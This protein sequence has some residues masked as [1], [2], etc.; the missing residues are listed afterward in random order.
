MTY[1]VSDTDHSWIKRISRL[2]V[3]QLVTSI[4]M[5]YMSV[6]EMRGMERPVFPA[7]KRVY[8]LA[9]LRRSLITNYI[10][11]NLRACTRDEDLKI[12]FEED[13]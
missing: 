2:P 3:Y 8:V 10:R 6:N 11:H 5:H 13:G 9:S 12:V 7:L 1:R 4:H